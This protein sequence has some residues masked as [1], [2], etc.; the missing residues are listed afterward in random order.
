MSKSD[1]Y[2]YKFV[3]QLN[4]K[5]KD[6]IAYDL[7]LIDDEGNVIREPET[8][9]EKKALNSFNRLVKNIKKEIEDTDLGDEI[10]SAS[11]ASYLIKEKGYYDLAETILEEFEIDENT[12][13]KATNQYL[14]E[15]VT[16]SA[17]PTGAN[18]GPQPDGHVMNS[19]FFDIDKDVFYRAYHGKKKNKH[20]KKF[21]KNDEN[22]EKVRQYARK[23]PKEKIWLRNNQ[24]QSEF[25]RV[26]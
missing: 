12:Y 14:T 17:V 1:F 4:R 5:W 26:K 18:I 10:G 22:S 11:L 6:W 9:D 16:T 19:P 8:R 2:A 23:Y 20:W 7:G 25:T 24:N 13:W 3:N 21:L 15:T